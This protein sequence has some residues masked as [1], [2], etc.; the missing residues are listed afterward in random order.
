M[1][2]G[3]LASIQTRLIKIGGRF[4]RHARGLV[5]QLAEVAVLHPVK[6]VFAALLERIGR[7]VL[8]PG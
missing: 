5:F 1:K 8:A 4:A 6:E 2:H 7:L 3:S